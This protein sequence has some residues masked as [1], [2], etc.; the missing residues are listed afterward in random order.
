MVR[1]GESRAI[2]IG[3]IAIQFR[4]D[5]QSIHSRLTIVIERLSCEIVNEKR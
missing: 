2:A 1:K 5:M 4:S 3:G